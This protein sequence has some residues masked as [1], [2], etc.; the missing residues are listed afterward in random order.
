[1]NEEIKKSI[2]NEIKA[3]VK[4]VIS[5]HIRPDGDAAG[6]SLGLKRI[7]E[8]TYPEKKVLVIGD[9]TAEQVKFI[10]DDDKAPEDSFYEG[11]LGIVVDTGTLDRISNAKIGLCD[12]IIKIDHHIDEK[13]FGDISWVEDFR[14]SCCEMIADFYNTFKDELKI[15]SYGAFCVYAGIVTDSGRFKYDGTTGDTLRLAST[16]LDFGFDTERMYSSIGLVSPEVFRF[17]EKILH[18]TKITENGV[19]YFYLPRS[20]RTRNKISIEK[21]SEMILLLSEIEGSL[22]W[23]AFLETDEGTIR[24]RLRSRFVGVQELASRYHGGGHRCASG[25]T[26]YSRK[27]MKALI[28][29]ADALLADY[30]EQN[31]G[32]M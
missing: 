20:V 5:R 2:L 28:R 11:A 6:A 12:K 29:D 10:G 8:L 13:P 17:R 23:I 1:M 22:I 4:I 24:V 14:S 7:I 30:K 3:Y 31:E 27:E 9:D 15:D 26:A 25:A 19:A 16:M 32:W 21:A 18:R